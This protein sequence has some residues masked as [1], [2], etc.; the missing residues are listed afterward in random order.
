[1]SPRA[2]IDY[3]NICRSMHSHVRIQMRIRYHGCNH[4]GSDLAKVR[5]TRVRNNIH[6]LQASH[7][8]IQH[9]K[10]YYNVNVKV[11]IHTQ[12]RYAYD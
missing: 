8:R 4:I 12:Y 10:Y 11:Q 6:H 5:L 3:N 9:G 7:M 2:I 1:M